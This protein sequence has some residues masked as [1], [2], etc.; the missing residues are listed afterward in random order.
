MQDRTFLLL[1]LQAYASCDDPEVSAACRDEFAR[2]YRF[3]AS[4][5][6]APDWALRAFFA[7]GMMMNVSA[8]MDLA[9]PSTRIG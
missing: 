8:A 3:V 5:S 1:Q 2:L 7:E 9:S 4:A 6:G